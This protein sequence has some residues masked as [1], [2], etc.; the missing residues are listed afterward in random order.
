MEA[1]KLKKSA[2][3]LPT[4]ENYLPWLKPKGE[5]EWRVAMLNI[6]S[7]G[8]HFEDLRNDHMMMNSDII[9]LVETWLLEEHD[10]LNIDQFAIH[11]YKLLLGSHNRGKGVALYVKDNISLHL[12][13]SCTNSGVQWLKVVTEKLD[14]LVLYRPPNGYTPD[15]LIR[16]IEPH[17]NTSRPCMITGKMSL[18]LKLG[19][20]L[21]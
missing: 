17:I 2:L 11:G 14:L 16:M 1:D 19:H 6:R 20:S 8:A 9:C 12:V 4:S 15:K 21:L 5:D 3:N 13:E 10:D 7:L 18:H